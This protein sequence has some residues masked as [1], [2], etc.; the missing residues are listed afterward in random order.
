[1]TMYPAVLVLENGRV[2][3]GNGFGAQVASHGEVVDP[4]RS[5]LPGSAACP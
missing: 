3:R 2:F 4:Y 1:M 5:G